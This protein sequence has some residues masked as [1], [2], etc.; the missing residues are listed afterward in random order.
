MI[1]F[2][3]HKEYKHLLTQ[4]NA[5]YSLLQSAEAII[6]RYDMR[7]NLLE[8]IEILKA[9]LESEKEMNRVLTEEL[10][11]CVEDEGYNYV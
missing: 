4:A 9:Q 8:D 5:L 7:R 10:E 1:K 2:K 6:T 11:K 3:P